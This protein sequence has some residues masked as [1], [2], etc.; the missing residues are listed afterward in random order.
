MAA[1]GAAQV[2]AFL[3]ERF[4]RTLRTVRAG[5]AAACALVLVVCGVRTE[6]LRRV[7]DASMQALT[8]QAQALY[9]LVPEEERDSFMAYRVEP[10]WYVAAEALPCMRFYFLQE[11]LA[12][13]DPAVMDEI[14]ATFE[15]EPPRWVVL[16]YNRPF[17]PPYDVRVQAILDTRYEFVDA[18][19]EYQLLHLKETL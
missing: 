14:V 11:I 5:A 7:G 15:S 12:D 13:A 2:L 18:Q 1:L 9:A 10:R 16:F 17:S 8:P 19:G 4:P 3:R 6:V